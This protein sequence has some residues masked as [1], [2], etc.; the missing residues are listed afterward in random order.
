MGSILQNECQWD[1]V[2]KTEMKGSRN[3]PEV[4]CNVFEALAYVE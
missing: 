2:E 3:V 4:H 1:Y